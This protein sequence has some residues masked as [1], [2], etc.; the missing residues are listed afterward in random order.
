MGGASEAAASEGASEGADGGGEELG[1]LFT[2]GSELVPCVNQALGALRDD[3]TL[4]SLEEE[5]LSQ[6][7]DIPTLTR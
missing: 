6:S 5:W 2:E 3:G 1:M 7:G 4:D